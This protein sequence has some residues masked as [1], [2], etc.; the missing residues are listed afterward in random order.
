V[1]GRKCLKSGDN[2]ISAYKE[3]VIGRTPDKFGCN[4]QKGQ[5]IL[6]RMLT[7]PTL[8]TEPQKERTITECFKC[9]LSQLVAYVHEYVIFKY[10]CKKLIFD[11]VH[12]IVNIPV[13]KYSIIILNELI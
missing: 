12:S 10:V 5:T 7:K 9:S 1:I 3:H 6:N 11:M 4:K 8:L 2:S 13:L